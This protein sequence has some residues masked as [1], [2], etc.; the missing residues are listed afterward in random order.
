M[1]K[2]KKGVM[3]CKFGHEH[4]PACVTAAAK[5]PTKPHGIRPVHCPD[6]GQV[7]RPDKMSGNWEIYMREE[8]IQK[9]MRERPRHDC[10]RKYAHTY[11]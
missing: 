5:N 2:T 6:C 3:A 4:P 9:A 11:N 10:L 8:E 1:Q 7:N